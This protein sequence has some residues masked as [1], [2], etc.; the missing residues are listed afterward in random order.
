MPPKKRPL[1]IPLPLSEPP[2]SPEQAAAF[3]QGLT[4]F[5]TGEY[6]HAHEAWEDAWKRMGDGPED[7]AEI[8][9]RGLI[10]LAAARHAERQGRPDAA[11]KN[12][13]KAKAKL[14][15]FEGRFWGV[16]IGELL[17]LPTRSP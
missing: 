14:A 17:A 3:A 13:E 16:E 4:L 10:Q 8:V 5:R 2:Q 9:L 12:M 1:D 11:R 15:L 6:W 7:D